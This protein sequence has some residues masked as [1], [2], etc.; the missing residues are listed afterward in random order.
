MAAVTLSRVTKRF[1]DTVAVDALDLVIDDGEFVV[2]L[3]PS[4]CG[5]STALRMIAGL[6]APTSGTIAIGGTVVNDVD[7]KDRDIAMVFQ[8]YALYP[9][10]SVRKNIAFPLKPRKVPRA[11]QEQ[12]VADAAAALGLTELLDR[13]PGQ[14]SGGQRQRVALARAIVRKPRV[15]L[16]DEPLSNLDAQMRSDT[17]GELVE[18]HRKLR[19]TFIYVTHDQIEAMTMAD[20]VAVMSGGKLQQVGPPQE[21]YERPANRF[22]A[23]FI[24]S[25]PMNVL[26]A[27]LEP[28]TATISVAGSVLRAPAAVCERYSARTSVPVELG[29]RPECLH[30][31]SPDQ[32]SV[33][34]RVASLE[35]LGHEVLVHTVAAGGSPVVVR[36]PSAGVGRELFVPAVDDIVHLAIDRADMH[37]FDPSS[38][39]RVDA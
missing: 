13:R 20:R 10:L 24:G 16:M 27:T 26:P 15:F 35:A 30:L 7:P 37:L 21:V 34:A 25:P 2:L 11:E 6:E 22:V 33:A 39:A 32:P 4:G 9:H 3:G 31:T 29:V 1:G 5:K 36:I 8:S 17:R 38:G 18:L 23:S 28:P 12:L 14:L 19:T